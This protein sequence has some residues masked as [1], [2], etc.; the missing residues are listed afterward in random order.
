MDRMRMVCMLMLNPVREL[1]GEFLVADGLDVAGC[2]GW[3]DVFCVVGHG[4]RFWSVAQ[5]S[6]I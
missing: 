6:V 4:E 1:G 5:V 3:S 2:F